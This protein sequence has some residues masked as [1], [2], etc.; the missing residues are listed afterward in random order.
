MEEVLADFGKCKSLA[1]KIFRSGG[2]F[3]AGLSV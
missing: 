2:V 1:V 3:A